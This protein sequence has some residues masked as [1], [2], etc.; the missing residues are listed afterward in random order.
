[1]K[2][3]TTFTIENFTEFKIKMLNWLRPFNIFCLLDNCAYQFDHPAFELLV[4]VGSKAR[5]DCTTGN[6]F[7]QMKAFNALHND[8]IFGHLAYDLKNETE[9]LHSANFDGIGF[10]N[11]HF[12]VPEIVLQYKNKTLTIF[13]TTNAA[14]IYTAIL[15]SSPVMREQEYPTLDIKKRFTQSEYLNAIQQLQQHIL[16]GD[17]YEV[18]FCQEFFATGAQIDPVAVYHKLVTL[19]PNPF[20]ALYRLADRYCICASPE[21]YLKKTG[22][23]IF[24]QPI[25][26]TAT[27]F[28]N[29]LQL[30]EESKLSLRKSEKE[31]SENVMV[32]DLVRNDFSKICQQ[33]T[34]Q[35]DELFGLYSFPQVHQMISTISGVLPEELDWT[36][37]VKASFPMGSMTGAPKKR[38]MEIIE[39]QER[40]KRGLFS[41]AIGYITPIK[42]VDFNVVIRSILYNTATK[43]LSFQAGSAITFNSDPQQE[44]EEC[45]LKAAVIQRVLS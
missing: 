30:D 29:N 19:S 10:G 40:T 14:D 20:A 32:V 28:I 31:K 43:Y 8:W 37:V 15:A 25:K 26:G 4:A 3:A 44:Y 9:Q 16:R 33:G 7:A 41:G 39:E 23:K 22:H 18:N 13:C 38:V 12:F 17:C 34:V 27:R 21:R 6:A 35:V 11:A 42:E 45:L 36:D 2:K 5:L 1:M 24:S